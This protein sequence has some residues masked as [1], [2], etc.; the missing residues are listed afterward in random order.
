MVGATSMELWNNAPSPFALLSH[1]SHCLKRKCASSLAAETQVMS[2]ALAEV[3]WIRG[4]F[5]ELTNPS[6]NIVEWAAKSRNRGLMVAARSSD[7]KLRLPKVLSIGD[8][9]SL[10]DHLHTET[11][12]YSDHS[13][14][15]GNSGRYCKMGGPW[16][17]VCRCD[18]Q[19]KWQHSVASDL[20]ADRSHMHY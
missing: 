4:L 10:Y 14:Q 1:K 8:A 17:H 11:Y 13:I 2:E 6:F 7:A 19:E 15:H 3:E 18:D 16:R 5:E 20:D 9:K 12:R